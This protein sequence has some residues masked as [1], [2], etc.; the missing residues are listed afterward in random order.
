MSHARWNALVSLAAMVLAA[1]AVALV[2]RGRGADHEG[3]VVPA[4][5]EKRLVE[6]EKNLDAI[7]AQEQSLRR[8]EAGLKRVSEALA[9]A[10]R[11]AQ[12]TKQPAEA[13][14]FPPPGKGPGKVV[15]EKDFEKD[16][17]GW[18]V[19]KMFAAIFTGDLTHATGE[20]EAKSGRGALKLS[21][22]YAAG[23][24]GIASFM[25]AR[26]KEVNQVDFWIRSEKKTLIYVAVSERD[27][28][29]YGTAFELG[30]A[31][32]WHRCVVDYSDFSL[33]DD[34][35]DENNILDPDQVTSVSISDLGAFVG[36]KG[37]NAILI[38]DFRGLNVP[39]AKVKKAQPPDEVF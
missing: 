10:R 7:G 26:L 1:V 37:K 33:G 3:A 39:R 38:D 11:A 27:N 24:I 6:I 35:K 23:K 2:W 34:S 21:H 18:M 17:F 20:G 16:I 8:I 4:A 9:A 25:G 28:S 30:P 13:E 12:A 22:E 14:I 15:I 29:Y 19:P 36:A 32:G 5:V 31:E